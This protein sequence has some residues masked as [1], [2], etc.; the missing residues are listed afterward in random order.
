MEMVTSRYFTLCLLC[1][2][3]EIVID[4]IMFLI[5]FISGVPSV[6]QSKNGL[7]L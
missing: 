7:E 4:L 5:P 2:L 3:K 6:E 1:F